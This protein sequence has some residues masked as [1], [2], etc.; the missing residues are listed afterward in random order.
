MKSGQSQSVVRGV[1]LALCLCCGP[2]QASAW[3]ARDLGGFGSSTRAVAL[4]DLGEVVGASVGPSGQYMA[5]VTGPDG[6]GLRA[7]QGL[8]PGYSFATDIN[9]HGVVVGYAA[10]GQGG[11]RTFITGPGGADARGLPLFASGQGGVAVVN[12]A[13]QVAGSASTATGEF[14]HYLTGAQGQGLTDLGPASYYDNAVGLT[15]DGRVLQSRE[16]AQGTACF[17]TGAQGQGGGLLPLGAGLSCHA[18]GLGPRAE[19]LANVSTPT[20]WTTG[21]ITG[22]GGLDSRPLPAGLFAEGLNGQ[23]VVVGHAQ[24]AFDR[25]HAFMTLAQAQGLV[26]LNTLVALPAGEFLEF[27]Y[28]VNESGQIIAESN[29]GRAFLLSPVPEPAA[30]LLTVAGLLTVLACT[31]RRPR[32]GP[33]LAAS[34]R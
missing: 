21:F 31:R 4:N 25:R 24:V 26:D 23:G 15:D 3:Q 33:E 32:G 19:V 1:A 2:A 13:G 20:G 10:D 8:E 18:A 16:L 6:I 22:P 30:W 34:G 7:L 17:L 27:A 14:R 11:L 9:A 5:F 29:L 12:G 28:D